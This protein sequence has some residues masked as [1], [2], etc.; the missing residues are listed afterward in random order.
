[1]EL[2]LICD[3]AF[4]QKAHGNYFLVVGDLWSFELIGYSVHCIYE[5]LKF[6]AH[7]N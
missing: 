4:T 2:L 6:R 3:E 5:H 1:M 7:L